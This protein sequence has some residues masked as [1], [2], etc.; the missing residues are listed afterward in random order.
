MS[1]KLFD[2]V[3]ENKE[4]ENFEKTEERLVRSEVAKQQQCGQC[5]LIMKK[6]IGGYKA[7]HSSWSSWQSPI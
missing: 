3:C 1:R 4:C 2:Y 6:L 5:G 7:K